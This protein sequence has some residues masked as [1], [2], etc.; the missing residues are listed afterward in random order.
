ML[1]QKIQ[2]FKLNTNSSL[3]KIESYS[4]P[5]QSSGSHSPQKKCFYLDNISSKG[6]SKTLLLGVVIFII[7]EIPWIFHFWLRHVLMTGHQTNLKSDSPSPLPF[8]VLLNT[9][10]LF[11]SQTCCGSSLMTPV[12]PK[13]IR[14]FFRDDS[15]L[16]SLEGELEVASSF[17]SGIS[18]DETVTLELLSLKIH[19]SY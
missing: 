1:R 7:G 8:F 9:K 16:L 11:P 3:G 17:S 5:E 19:L 4:P 15:F 18:E 10:T 2:G 14:L 12:F 13:R 6:A